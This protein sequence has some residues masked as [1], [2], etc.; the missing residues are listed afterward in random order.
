[1]VNECTHVLCG[2][3]AYGILSAQAPEVLAQTVAGLADPGLMTVIKPGAARWNALDDASH[4]PVDRRSLTGH[5]YAVHLGV[6]QSPV[7]RTGFSG[8]GSLA[9]WGPNR[10]MVGVVTKPGSS[11]QRLVLVEYVNGEWRFPEHRMAPG[12]EDDVALATAVAG[13]VCAHKGGVESSDVPALVEPLTSVLSGT[14]HT[15]HKGAHEHSLNTD[16]AWVESVV[17]ACDVSPP[18]VDDALSALLEDNGAQLRWTALSEGTLLVADQKALLEPILTALP[19]YEAS[20]AAREEHRHRLSV[21][22][23]TKAHEVFAPSEDN[24]SSDKQEE[25]VEA[26]VTE[27]L[28]AS[29]GSGRKSCLAP[30]NTM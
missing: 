18:D 22:V 13:G 15:L 8:R 19:A 29:A 20:A 25:D 3:V 2:D 10:R 24:E 27:L 12:E 5:A 11:G 4:P 30:G 23:K 7:G 28:L 21:K 6:P 9:W 26:T 17:V 16:N 1:M 14:T